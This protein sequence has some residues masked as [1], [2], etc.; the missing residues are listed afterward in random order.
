MARER[1]DPRAVTTLIGEFDDWRNA[2]E[3]DRIAYVVFVLTRRLGLPN[4]GSADVEA[5][6]EALGTPLAAAR[7]DGYL[8]VRPDRYARDDS[9]RFVLSLP[10]RDRLEARTTL[11]RDRLLAS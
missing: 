7:A 1:F 11:A 10:Y 4:V 3:E 2:P 8:K 6:L 5:A 9:G